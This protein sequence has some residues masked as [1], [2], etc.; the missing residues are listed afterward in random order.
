MLKQA[1]ERGEIHLKYLD[2]SGVCLWSPVGYS[3]SR[4]GPQKRMEQ[5]K[6]VQKGRIRILGLWEEHV[7]FEYGLA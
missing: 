6:I 7:G 5:P 4:I 1:A 3:Y 2:E